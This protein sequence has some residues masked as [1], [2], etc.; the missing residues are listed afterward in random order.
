M[1]CLL[2][3]AP[4]N[5]YLDFDMNNTRPGDMVWYFCDDDFMLSGTGNRTCEAD[6]T[7]SEP[8]PACIPEGK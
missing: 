8:E 2:P 5:G 6:G 7:W 1:K 3:C 4:S